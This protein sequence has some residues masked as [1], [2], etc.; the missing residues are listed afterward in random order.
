MRCR[1]YR[2]G[3]LGAEGPDRAGRYHHPAELTRRE[4][5]PDRDRGWA[6]VTVA[7]QC[8]D[9]GRAAGDLRRDAAHEGFA[10]GATNQQDGPQRCARDRP[11][12]S[13][14]TASESIA[15]TRPKWAPP[16]VPG[17]APRSIRPRT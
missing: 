11:D 1:R 2:Q 17:S 12:I 14:M 4:L 10:D 6:A 8:V 16:R 9:G 5:R 3:N 15:A 13:M 7:G